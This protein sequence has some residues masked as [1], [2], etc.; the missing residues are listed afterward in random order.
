MMKQINQ[1]ANGNVANMVAGDLHQYY[2][3]QDEQ[4]IREKRQKMRTELL[5]YRTSNPQLHNLLC[6]YSRMAFGE[7]KFVD[8]DDIQLAKLYQYYQT[9]LSISST[10][11]EQS[12]STKKPE[13]TLKYHKILINRCIKFLEKWR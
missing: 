9:I 8:L 12:I 3:A 11:S 2:Y 4:T 10:L 7:G 1:H 6:D 13:P 5:Q